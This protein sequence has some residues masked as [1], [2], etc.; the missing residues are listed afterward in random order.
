V[1][2][3]LFASNDIELEFVLPAVVGSF[4]MSTEDGSAFRLGQPY[5]GVNYVH[6]THWYWRF[7]LGAGIA[8]MPV[9]AD[10]AGALGLEWAAAMRGWWDLWLWSSQRL[11]FVAPFRFEYDLTE[12]GV[13]DIV[14]GV[15]PTSSATSRSS[16]AP[17]VGII[18]AEPASLWLLA[19]RLVAA[20]SAS[21]GRLRARA[22]SRRRACAIFVGAVLACR[23]SIRL[24][25][26]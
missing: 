6:S 14:F 15:G 23:V 7:R 12:A 24:P 16:P 4:D 19:Q 17:V 9:A 8:W 10:G 2:V 5:A 26:G 25:V 18:N 20:R 22:P 11:S 3:G 21:C 1:G 13:D